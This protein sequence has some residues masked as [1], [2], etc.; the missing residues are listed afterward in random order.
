MGTQ[1]DGA[2]TAYNSFVSSIERNLL[3]TTRDLNKRSLGMLDDNKLIVDLPELSETTHRFT[4]AE[5]AEGSEDDAE[6]EP[7]ALK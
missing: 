5:L 7:K 1:L 4:K 6:D 3:T 2:V